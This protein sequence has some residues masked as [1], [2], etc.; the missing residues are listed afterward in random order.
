MMRGD[1]TS[2]HARFS[3]DSSLG[4]LFLT[5]AGEE[6]QLVMNLFAANVQEKIDAC[7]G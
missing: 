5:V 4:G 6:N 3:D 7:T 2:R 1:L